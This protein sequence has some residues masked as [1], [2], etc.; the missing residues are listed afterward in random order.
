M[1]RMAFFTAPRF[2]GPPKRRT[3]AAPR[4]PDRRIG[5]TSCRCLLIQVLVEDLLRSPV[6]ESRVKTSPIVPQLDVPGNCLL[7]F[8]PGRVDGPVDQLDL[9]RRIHGLGQGIVIAYPGPAHGLPYPELFQDGGE[10]RAD[11]LRACLRHSMRRRRT[12]PRRRW[13]YRPSPSRLSCAWRS[14]LRSRG[15]ASPATSGCTQY[16]LPFSPRGRPRRCRGSP[17]PGSA[18]SR[19]PLERTPAR[20]AAGS[21]P[22]PGP[23]ATTGAA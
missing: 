3:W 19:P 11:R 13:H 17:G 18:R 6:S 5:A 22:A 7:S 16:R 4:F 15:K 21:P 9:D 2:F 10:L 23:P 8:L 20:S 12:G 14:Q 1:A